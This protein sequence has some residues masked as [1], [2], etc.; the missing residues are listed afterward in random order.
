M[1]RRIHLAPFVVKPVSIDKDLKDK[2]RDEWPAIL[3]GMIEGCLAWQRQGLNPPP[4]VRATTDEYFREEDAVGQ[5]LDEACEESPHAF[6]MLDE[7]FGSWREYCG[8]LGINAGSVRQFSQALA[9]RGLKRGH[10]SRTRRTGYH[11][12]VLRPATDGLVL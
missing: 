8:R 6:T 5:W 10:H 11:G 3:A 1:K 12:I 7:L 4:V 9:N 2:L